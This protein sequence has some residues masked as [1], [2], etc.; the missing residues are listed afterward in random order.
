MILF[1]FFCLVS[2]FAEWETQ[3]CDFPKLCWHDI[4]MSWQLVD[5]CLQIK[6]PRNVN[7][8]PHKVS[9]YCCFSNKRMNKCNSLSILVAAKRQLGY[10][11]LSNGLFTHD[12]L[13]RNCD[14]DILFWDGAL[15]GLAQTAMAETVF[16]CKINVDVRNGHHG[17]KGRYSHDSAILKTQNSHCRHSVNKATNVD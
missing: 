14:W 7:G 8:I 15:Y 13:F 1:S 5:E 10:L 2:T 16:F 4:L 17:N 9:F 12:F 11:F 3:K 6:K